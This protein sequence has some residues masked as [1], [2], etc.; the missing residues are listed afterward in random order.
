MFG[1][2]VFTRMP[3]VD[4]QCAKVFRKSLFTEPKLKESFSS[5]VGRSILCLMAFIM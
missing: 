1:S 3:D 5:A 2:K 4:L